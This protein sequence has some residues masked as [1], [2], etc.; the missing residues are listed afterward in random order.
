MPMLGRMVIMQVTG[1]FSSA[2]APK[3]LV[4]AKAKAKAKGIAKAKAKAAAQPVQ[5]EDATLPVAQDVALPNGQDGDLRNVPS[6]RWVCFSSDPTHIVCSIGRD[7]DKKVGVTVRTTAV[8]RV[9]NRPVTMAHPVCRL[10][11]VN[12]P[13]SIL[14]LGVGLPAPDLPAECRWQLLGLCDLVQPG[15][16]QPQFTVVS[17]T[18]IEH[19]QLLIQ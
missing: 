8:Q 7:D 19:A 2:M 13:G 6:A 9:F 15:M 5:H 16:Q 12:V 4:A 18:G 17:N 1:S 3:V 11:E 10:Q 14:G